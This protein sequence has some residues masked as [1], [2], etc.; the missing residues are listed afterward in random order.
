MQRFGFSQGGGKL[1]AL[2]QHLDEIKAQLDV[3]RFKPD[4]VLQ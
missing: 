2:A 1:L 3:V 4:R